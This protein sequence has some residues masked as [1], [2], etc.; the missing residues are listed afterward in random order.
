MRALFLG[1]KKWT[2]AKRPK[3]KEASELVVDFGDMTRL[4]DLFGWGGWQ[5]AVAVGGGKGEKR[6]KKLAQVKREG[7]FARVP[8][9]NA[10]HVD[11][12]HHATQT[13][14]W[15]VLFA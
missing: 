9:T 8:R 2:S 11:S 7:A 3:N 12:T 15:V 4:A 14:S 6:K 1:E 5:L 10:P 13:A